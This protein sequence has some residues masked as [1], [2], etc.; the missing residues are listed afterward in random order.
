ML[1]H[2]DDAADEV[3]TRARRKPAGHDVDADDD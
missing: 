3:P 1:N 2:D